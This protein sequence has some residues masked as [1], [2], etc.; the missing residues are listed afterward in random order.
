M[1]V[2]FK[3]LYEVFYSGRFLD[4]LGELVS[5]EDETVL[6]TANF[7]WIG[8]V[9]IVISFL[10]AFAFYIWPIDHPRF[11]SWWSWLIMFIVNGILCF[12]EAIGFACI[13]VSEIDSTLSVDEEEL[14]EGLL[15]SSLP[16]AT[17]DTMLAD[18][19]SV[20]QYFDFALQNAMWACVAFIIVSLIFNWFSVNCKN[21]PFRK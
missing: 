19:L 4:I 3:S 2:F 13:R 8:M 15:N 16:Y 14:W 18:S 5:E 12:F 21:S 10:L 11:K 1:N 20:S 7:A 17:S 9:A 6:F